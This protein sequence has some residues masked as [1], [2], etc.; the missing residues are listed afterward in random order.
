MKIY[1]HKNQRIVLLYIHIRCFGAA[2]KQTKKFGTEFSFNPLK[3]QNREVL[4]TVKRI[5]SFE[6]KYAYKSLSFQS[7]WRFIFHVLLCWLAL[8]DFLSNS[9]IGRFVLCFF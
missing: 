3:T 2:A 6:E 4:C 9:S 1:T 8:M 7:E 5:A